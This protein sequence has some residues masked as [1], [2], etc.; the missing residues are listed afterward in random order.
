MVALLASRQCNFT[1]SWTRI[2]STSPNTAGL[3]DVAL[4]AIV[5]TSPG[6]LYG[7][8]VGNDG[9]D[10]AVVM[11]S[12]DGGISW[13]AE[14]IY[15]SAGAS[16]Y[17]NG[18]EIGPDGTLIATGVAD[19]DG[20]NR[21]FFLATKPP[22]GS[23]SLVAKYERQDT[24]ESGAFQAA[25]S[26]SG[27]H[28]TVGLGTNSTDT[29]GVLMQTD[30][31]LAAW[32]AKTIHSDSTHS[33]AWFSAIHAVS[34]S[35]IYLGGWATGTGTY[36][37]TI[38]RAALDGTYTELNRHTITCCLGD[39]SLHDPTSILL[40]GSDVLVAYTPGNTAPSLIPSVLHYNLDSMTTTL[41]SV[42]NQS[43]AVIHLAKH[44]SRIVASSLVPTTA[45]PN[46]SPMV[47]ISTDGGYTF[48]TSFAPDTD[49]LGMND[50]LDSSL[51]TLG[52]YQLS[53]GSLL[54]TVPV[55]ST[56]H[57]DQPTLIYKTGCFQYQN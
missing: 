47:S 11:K 31:S 56:V 44:G 51:R 32:N 50:S 39:H 23:F 28:Y 48:A 18:L 42:A 29:A 14:W 15:P 10:R 16:P 55:D 27:N 20:T 7:G 3:T 52:T 53:D 37:V 17:I 57:P 41:N 35:E 46:G 49:G 9:A 1:G 2:G 45:A 13:S 40:N 5:E 6:V 19:V 30:A 43:G 54:F 38:G 22:G 33:T 4:V 8:G 26:P 24:F 25:L 21:E 36:E 34:D 12:E